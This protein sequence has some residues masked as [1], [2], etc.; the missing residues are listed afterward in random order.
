MKV[1]E[2]A[3]RLRC[4]GYDVPVCAI[5][6]WTMKERARVERWLAYRNRNDRTRGR[7][8]E[9]PPFLE[10]YAWGLRLVQK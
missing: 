6:T 9:C 4:Y 8:S 5:N 10:R 2:M 7:P 1:Y 3:V